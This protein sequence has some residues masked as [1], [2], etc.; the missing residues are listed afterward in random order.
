MKSIIKNAVLGLAL[1]SCAAF[2]SATA[3]ISTSIAPVTFDDGSTLKTFSINSNGL[4]DDN[5]RSVI[6]PMAGDTFT[7][8]FLFN[9]PDAMSSFAFFANADQGGVAF[10]GAAFGYITGGQINGI[11]QSFSADG[12][13]GS[14]LLSSATYDLRLT[15][16]FLADGGSFSGLAG[17]VPVDI[18]VDTGTVPEPMSLSLIGLGLAGM[19]SL[20]RRK[21]A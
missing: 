2:A 20:R 18:P 16:S 10:D 5:T 12:V 14:G 1:S 11:I 13:S 9:L 6:A 3:F 15:G 21:A 19:A 8:D 4:V 7:F 17:A